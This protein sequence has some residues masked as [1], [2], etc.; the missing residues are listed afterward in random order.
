MRKRTATL[1]RQA[2]IVGREA[3]PGRSGCRG[4]LATP[5][6]SRGKTDRRQLARAGMFVYV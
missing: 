5:C 6:G 2:D 4:A 3:S 1:R